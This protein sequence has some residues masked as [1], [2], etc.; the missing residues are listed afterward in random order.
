DFVQLIMGHTSDAAT[1]TGGDGTATHVMV[2]FID[3]ETEDEIHYRLGYGTR[4]DKVKEAYA[5][6]TEVPVTSLQFFFDSIEVDDDDTPRSLELKDD[7]V[8][9]VNVEMPSP[10]D[11]NAGG[12]GIAEHFKLKFVG[13]DSLKGKTLLFILKNMKVSMGEL[14]ND[15]A[16]NKGVDV[17]TLGFLFRGCRINNEDTPEKLEIKKKDVVYVYQQQDI[18][19]D[20]GATAL[21]STSGD[22]KNDKAIK[23]IFIDEDSWS[24]EMNHFTRVACY[25]VKHGSRLGG[26]KKRFADSIGADAKSLRFL[27][28]GCR[29]GDDETLWRKNYEDDEVITVFSDMIT[30]PWYVCPPEG[31]R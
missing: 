6:R 4:M 7:D 15:Y 5:K 31:R 11:A 27:R 18:T 30:C 1:N 3:I 8:I 25:P 23:M 10:V 20:N 16:E 22:N 14:K 17:S 9:D 29:V 12:D 21:T 28:D 24:L 13:Q 19:E 26:V 2:K